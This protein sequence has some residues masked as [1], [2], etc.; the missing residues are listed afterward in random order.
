[1]TMPPMESINPMSDAAMRRELSHAPECGIRSDEDLSA[2]GLLR[3]AP[4]PSG[5]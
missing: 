1:M 5:R 4:Q 3:G 2:E